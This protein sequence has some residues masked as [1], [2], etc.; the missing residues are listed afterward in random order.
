[1][2][3]SS[4]EEEFWSTL[5][6]EEPFAAGSRAVSVAVLVVGR[7][8]WNQWLQL[9]LRC[10]VDSEADLAAA[11]EEASAIVEVGSV[12]VADSA[13]GAA[14]VTGAADFEVGEDSEVAIEVASGEAL[15]VAE[16]VEVTSGTATEATDLA[17]AEVAAEASGKSS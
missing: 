10:A 6:E 5:S 2:V 4:W 13:T 8:A 16:K 12:T 17:T 11:D 3:W 14:S 15:V 7:N 9:L 1:M